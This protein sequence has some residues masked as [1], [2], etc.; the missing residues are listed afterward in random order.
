MN[1]KS[2]RRSFDR[3]MLEFVLEVSAADNEGKRFN[4]NTV[5]QNISGG[6]AKFITKQTDKYFLG[7]LLEMTIYLPGTGDVKAYMNGKATV[8][9]IDPSSNSG[10]GKKNRE[11]GL[12]VKLEAPLYFERVDMKIQ[13]DRR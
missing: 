8:V 2:D 9:R 3:F 10:I 12:A 4:E 6:G 1:S 13:G 7:Q 11:I 5:L